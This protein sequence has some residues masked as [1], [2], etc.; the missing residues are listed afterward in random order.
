MIGRI[1]GIIILIVVLGTAANDTYRYLRAEQNLR[2][3]TYELAKYAGENASA[4]GREGVAAQLAAMAAPRGVRVY[5]Y[6]QGEQGVG[7][8]TSTNA[9]GTIVVGTVAGLIAGKPFDEAFLSPFEIRDYRQTNY[10]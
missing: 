6:D 10:Q 2:D 3:T 1:L 5:Q 4:L 7:V 8:W 9:T